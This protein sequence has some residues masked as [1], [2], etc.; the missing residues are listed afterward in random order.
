MTVKISKLEVGGIIEDTKRKTK[1]LINSADK[2]GGLLETVSKKSNDDILH[3]VYM[4]ITEEG[5]GNP[6]LPS[7]ATERVTGNQKQ[8]PDFKKQLESAGLGN[9]PNFLY[10]KFLILS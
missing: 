9:E 5:N 6:M 3:V 1:E 8:Y 10:S 4:L 7:Y 2:E